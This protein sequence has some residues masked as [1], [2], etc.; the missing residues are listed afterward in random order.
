MIRASPLALVYLTV[1]WSVPER[2]ARRAFQEAIERLS[3]D[4]P[5]IDI[6]FYSLDEEDETVRDFLKPLGFPMKYALG[7]GSLIWLES[8]RMVASES[9][10]CLLDAADIVER[11]LVLWG[12]RVRS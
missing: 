5:A 3:A 12:D 9:Y 7:S 2:R 10:G 11:T 6:A 4:H 8:G 1:E